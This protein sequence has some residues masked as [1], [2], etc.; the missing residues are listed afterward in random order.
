MTKSMK[1]KILLIILLFLIFVKFS[2]SHISKPD[3]LI[4]Y[5]TDEKILLNGILNEN[6]WS[7]ASKISNFIQREPDEGKPVSEPTYATVLYNN[8]KL[9][10]GLWAYDSNPNKIIAKDMARDGRWGSSDNFEIIISPFNDKRNAYLFVVNPNGARGDAI[11]TDNGNGWNEDWNGVWDVAVVKND[12]GWFAEIEIPFSTLKFKNKEYQ[13]WGFNIERN[14]R[15]KN[16]QATWQGWS[17]NFSVFQVSESGVL[18][19]LSNIRSSEIFE[20]KPYVTTGFQ[21]V[22]GQN[23]DKVLKTGGEVNINFTPTTK[24]NLTANTDFSQVESDRAFINLTRFSI[25]LPEKREFFI[26]NRN[27]FTFYMASGM[28][29]FYSRKIGIESGEEIPIIGGIKLTG[30]ENKTNF[31]IISIQ[32]A[33]RGDIP[34]ANYSVLRVKQDISSQSSIGFITTAKNIKGHYNY[35]YGFDFDYLKSDFLK[36]KNFA[37]GGAI[38]QTQTKNESNSKNLAYQLYLSYPNDQI[39]Y[40]LVAHSLEKKYNP[41]MGFLYREN[42][43]MISSTLEIKPRPKKM[44]IVKQFSFKPLDVKYYISNDSKTLESAEFLIR[45]LGFKTNSG[46]WF[47]F[48][49]IRT[50]ELIPYEF[51]IYK[52]ITIPKGEYWFNHY[53]FQFDTYAGRKFYLGTYIDFGDFYNGKNTKTYINFMWYPNKHFNIS[54]DWIRNDVSLA[55]G[56]FITNEIGSRLEYAFTPKL[57]NSIYSQWNNYTQEVLLNYRIHWIPKVGSDF[58][59][60][61]NQKVKTDSGNIKFADF[62]LLAKLIWRFAV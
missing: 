6:S 45:P 13:H 27:L 42:I 39:N 60:A 51:N 55:E 23:E 19:G 54:T 59:L 53:Q 8:Q 7:K 10:I 5:Y 38:S 50:F 11:I 35:L 28:Y 3:T 46:E 58:Y 12:S 30:K 40:Y 22:A 44:P 29:G 61:V 36:N 25:Y 43:S 16:E 24:L 37:F 14:I 9:Y 21:K 56:K 47:E 32:T 33:E 57:L 20:F 17:R 34:T 41:E 52:N 26:E 62:A 49:L 2:F 15:Y 18:S 4:S 1:K 48:D 31:G